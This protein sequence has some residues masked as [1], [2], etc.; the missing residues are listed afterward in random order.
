[1]SKFK[2]SSSDFILGLMTPLTVNQHDGC[3]A[4]V[5]NGKTLSCCE[6]ERYIRYK[7]GMGNLP[8]NAIY[9]ALKSENLTIK[10]IKAIFISSIEHPDLKR[11]VQLYLEHYFG[12]APDL[13]MIDHQ[14]AHLASAYY[15]SGY[16]NA[17][18]LSI[19]GFGDFK[20]M[21]FGEG[22][23]NKI[24]VLENKD[25]TQSLGILYTTI[26]Q[27]LGFGS[28]G[29]EYKL[30][31]LAAYG[32][33]GIDLSTIIKINNND[34]FID[35]NYLKRNPQTKNIKEPRYGPKLIELFGKPRVRGEKITD[36]H[37]DLA[38]ALQDAFERAVFLMH[39]T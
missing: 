2:I 26:T 23:K 25:L 3:A 21:S 4:L 1:M 30:M 5:S 12:H 11:R 35:K 16:E 33:P 10:D 37:K 24:T 34:Y 15:P 39:K 6:E 38:F 8:I 36:F 18:L 19:D 13:H 31:G 28:V 22:K 14:V 20:S 9:A 27:F 17:M 29:D 32:K 7:H